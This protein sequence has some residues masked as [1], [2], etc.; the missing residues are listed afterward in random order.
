VVLV[1]LTTPLAGGDQSGI[2]T[3][4]PGFVAVG[5]PTT[6]LAVGQP[7]PELTGVNDGQPVSLTDLDGNPITL[8]ALRGHAVWI[9]FWASWCPPCQQETPVLRDVYDAHKADGLELV[10]ISVQESTPD[11]VRAYVQR[12][13]LDFT[14]GFDATSA[15]FHTYDAYVLPTQVFIDRDGIVRNVTLGAVSR[16]QVEQILAPL[17]A[18]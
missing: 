7:A 6:G 10:A 16:D 15:I 13:G 8:A 2:P 11:D 4:A 1:I 12:Y 5:Q 14:V 17:L 18:Q 3:P 9:N